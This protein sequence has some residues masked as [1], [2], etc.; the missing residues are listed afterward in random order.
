MILNRFLINSKE[1]SNIHTKSNKYG[2]YNFPE[3]EPNLDKYELADSKIVIYWGNKKL[4][5]L[6][7]HQKI[8]FFPK[9]F[10]LQKVN[11]IYS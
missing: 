7:N 4:K 1:I 8:T 3:I 5:A 2:K 11:L 6:K 9:R 10:E